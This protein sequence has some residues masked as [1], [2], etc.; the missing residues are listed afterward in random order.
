MQCEIE[1]L[2]ITIQERKVDFFGETYTT[3]GCKPDKKKVTAITKMPVP[4]SKKQVQPFIR[5]INYLSKFSARLCI[6]CIAPL[7]QP[8]IFY[9]LLF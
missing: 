5:M 1:L 6:A 2:E 7:Q 9:H 4:T 3:S 8:K